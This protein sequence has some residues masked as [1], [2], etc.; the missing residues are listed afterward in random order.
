MGGSVSE[1]R[2]SVAQSRFRPYGNA[3]NKQIL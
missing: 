1:V 2:R 3:V